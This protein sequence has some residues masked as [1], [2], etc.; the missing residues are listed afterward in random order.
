M[1]NQTKIFKAVNALLAPLEIPT[2]RARANNCYL[3][4]RTINTV[5]TK[6]KSLFLEQLEWLIDEITDKRKE[7]YPDRYQDLSTPV[8]REQLSQL[9]KEKETVLSG[10]SLM[11]ALEHETGSRLPSNDKP[12]PVEALNSDDELEGM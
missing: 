4:V 12:Y 5:S 7:M 2:K 1:N 9:E 6:T 8:L 10:L 3:H 11:E